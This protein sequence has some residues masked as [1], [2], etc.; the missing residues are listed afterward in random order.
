MLTLHKLTFC[1]YKESTT[2]KSQRRIHS[3]LRCWLH[4]EILEIWLFG[5]KFRHDSLCSTIPYVMWESLHPHIQFR[6]IYNFLFQMDYNK[7]E[8]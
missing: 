7:F 4:L 6:Y 2:Y 5:V 3:K 1:V 8:F